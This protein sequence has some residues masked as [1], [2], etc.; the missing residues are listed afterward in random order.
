MSSGS[1]LSPAGAT[2]EDSVIPNFVGGEWVPSGSTDVLDVTDPGTGELLGRVPRSTA[3]DVAEAVRAAADAFPAWR[4]TP[5]VERVR[6]LFP[7]LVCRLWVVVDRDRQTHEHRSD[8]ST[9]SLS[10]K[11]IRALA[12]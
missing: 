2:G 5:A 11:G 4:A 9:R 12:P 3:A 10:L 8:E 6:V 7:S 1:T